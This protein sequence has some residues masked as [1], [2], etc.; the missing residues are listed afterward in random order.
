MFRKW[1]KD[2]KK[3]GN[4]FRRGILRWIE[5][6]SGSRLIRTEMGLGLFVMAQSGEAVKILN[7]E[8]FRPKHW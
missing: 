2:F 5:S 3:S 7:D 4:C 1:N 8:Q 6:I